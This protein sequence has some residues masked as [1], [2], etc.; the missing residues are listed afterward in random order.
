[1]KILLIFVLIFYH[2]KANSEDD[3]KKILFILFANSQRVQ[4]QIASSQCSFETKTLRPTR[5]GYVSS[6]HKLNASKWVLYSGFS[7]SHL[8][9]PILPCP[10]SRFEEYDFDTGLFKTTSL[11][12]VLRLGH[13]T[14][15]LDSTRVLF[16]G[17]GSDLSTIT[18]SISL[19]N[20]QTA[21]LLG[22]YNL[23]N[24]RRNLG[25]ILLDNGKIL[26]VGGNTTVSSNSVT[27]SEIFNP[28]LGIASVSG[29]M[30][31]ARTSPKLVKLSNGRVLIY[32]GQDSAGKF[33]KELEL[34]NSSTETFQNLGILFGELENFTIQN[35]ENTLIVAGGSIQ[36]S[37]SNLT[38]ILNSEN[39]SVTKST[40]MISQR[41]SPKFD[42]LE[43]GNYFVSS[44]GSTTTEIYS[45][46]SKTFTSFCP[47][48]TSG[49]VIYNS[50]KLL[51]TGYDESGSS[52]I[53]NY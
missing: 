20:L 18:S 52:Q 9:C 5:G 45:P 11:N 1:M 53:S 35:I 40:D 34:F 6:V 2:C 41:T 10:Y 25:S 8:Q 4:N 33:V 29:N 19:Y 14:V 32:G 23:L 3:S 39:F 46:S 22:T 47:I 30:N 27:S 43:N 28:N 15:E 17:G 44:T 38:Y 37:N 7:F 36:S 16:I 49:Y 42:R 21:S 26:V 12:I 50:N 24:A 51:I 13:G 48:T 31:L